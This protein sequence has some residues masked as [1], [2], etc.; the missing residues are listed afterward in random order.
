MQSDVVM[1][2]AID[3]TRDAAGPWRHVARPHR[4]QTST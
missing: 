2:V 4:L 1:E 3:A